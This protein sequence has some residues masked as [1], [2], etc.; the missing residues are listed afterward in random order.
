MN[1]PAAVGLLLAASLSLLPLMAR[2][3]DAQED[4]DEKPAYWQDNT[5]IGLALFQSVTLSPL[6]SLRTGLGP[7][8]P[9]SLAED[10][11]EVRVNEDWAR[12]L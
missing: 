1:R 5:N 3:A 11:I 4:V 10:G 12:V 2:T 8:L 7:R 6:P 9:S